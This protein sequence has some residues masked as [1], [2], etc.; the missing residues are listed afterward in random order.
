VS[1]AQARLL[2]QRWDLGLDAQTGFQVL[3]AHRDGLGQ[4]HVRFQQ[5]YQGVPVFGG[6]AISHTGPDG[7]VL[8]LTDALV[9]GIQVAVQPTL[10]PADVLAR[11]Q[12]DLC[13]K[14]P[15]AYPPTVERVLWP[16]ATSANSPVCLLAYHVHTQ[17]ENGTAETAHTDYIIDAH[18]GAIL[19]KW[20]SLRSKAATG[21]GLTQYSGTVK[22]DTNRTAKGFELRDLTRGK[23]GAFGNNAI[24]NLDHGDSGDGA[25]AESAAGTWGNHANYTGNEE[26][27]TGA[28]GQTAMA[29]AAYGTQVT[30]DMFHH[31]F[32]RNGIDGTGK[33]TFGRVHYSTSYD[34]AFWDDTCFC[35]TYGDG[36]QFT[37]LEALDVAGHEIAHGVCSTTANLTYTGESGG[38]NEANS[39]IF[40]TLAEFYARGGGYAASAD[41][42]PDTGGNWTIGEQLSSKPLRYMDRPSKDGSSPDAW[43]AGLTDLDVHLGSGPMNRCFYFLS[44]GAGKS[45]DSQTGYLPTGMKGVGNQAAARIWYRTLTAYLTSQSGYKEARAGA[46]R[47]ASDLYGAG[48]TEEKA[49][50]R[51]F[52]GINVGPDWSPISARILRPGKD[53]V[54]LSGTTLAFAGS[55]EDSLPGT[56]LTY[57]WTF[58]DG[59]VAEGAT[60][61]HRYL[62][63]SALDTTFTATFNALDDQ[64]NL[65]SD[66]R[67]LVVTPP[68]TTHPERLRNGG[69]EEGTTAWEGNTEVIGH[70]PDQPPF[71]GKSN[72]LFT[73]IGLPTVQKLQQALA[74]PPCAG[75]TLTFRLHIDSNQFLPLPLDLCKVQIVDGAGVLLQEV[76]AY[77]NTDAN[78]GYALETFD[79]TAFKGQPVQ[80]RFEV[81]EGWLFHTSFGLD[82]V[83][84]RVR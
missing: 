7:Q 52:H 50:R 38:L 14:G 72:A 31:V 64:G 77:S 33:A 74:I 79:L 39:D 26:S 82:N 65:G 23:G 41:T 59:G 1:S 10:T 43:S 19:K 16:V 36:S 44:Q 18:T 2:A 45:G 47:A 53:Q 62:N 71:A 69:F 75:A 46:I 84:V 30:W 12:I 34:N 49:V 9:R 80:L 6:E 66:T 5:T 3:T 20:D 8:P 63:A 68:I 32:A 67:T 17:L 28:T 73:G 48:S 60:A 13:P 11:I 76:A 54:I 61:T 4:S 57:G 21:E 27:T 24:T 37:S 29:D 22:L 70:F 42:L 55:A 35:M 56:T 51:A 83:S 58:G 78:A 15:F 81:N 25:I 40:G